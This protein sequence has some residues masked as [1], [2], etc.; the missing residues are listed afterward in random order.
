[1]GRIS[2]EK[3]HV[4]I[5]T[6]PLWKFLSDWKKGDRDPDRFRAQCVCVSFYLS[7]EIGHGKKGSYSST[8]VSF[9]QGQM[10][11]LAGAGALFKTHT[12]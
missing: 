3:K 5:A 9:F 12:H 11:Y 8:L 6:S 7:C 10:T 1:M 4:E 2:Q